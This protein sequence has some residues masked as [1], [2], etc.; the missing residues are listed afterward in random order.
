MSE[1]VITTIWLSIMSYWVYVHVHF[2]IALRVYEPELY[3]SNDDWSPFKYATGFAW[4]DLA[5]SNGHARSG[6][7]EV[8]KAGNRLKYAYEMKFRIIGYGIGLSSVWFAVSWLW[9]AL[10]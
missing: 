3:R 7:A 2:R 10:K 9:G 4:V 6:N 5:L 1:F 8:V